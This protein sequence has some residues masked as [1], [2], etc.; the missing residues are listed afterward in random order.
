MMRRILIG[1]YHVAVDTGM[2]DY[3]QRIPVL[4]FGEMFAEGGLNIL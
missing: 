3:A 1:V 4:L 2:R